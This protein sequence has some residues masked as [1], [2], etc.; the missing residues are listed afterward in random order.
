MLQFKVI[1]KKCVYFYSAPVEAP[2][3][4]VPVPVPAGSTSSSSSSSNTSSGNTPQGQAPTQVSP[5]STEPAGAVG[6]HPAPASSTH[7]DAVL[8]EKLKHMGKSKSCLFCFRKVL[9]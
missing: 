4:N 3:S 9:V 6:G 2:S 7:D 5:V 1:Y 8:R